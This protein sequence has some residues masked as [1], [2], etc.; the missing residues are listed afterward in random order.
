[1]NRLLTAPEVADL[2]G[3][4]V[5]WIYT[6]AKAGRLPSVLVGRQRRFRLADLERWLDQQSQ[7]A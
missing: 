3:V 5:N 1:M 7:A 2:L 6:E 4:H